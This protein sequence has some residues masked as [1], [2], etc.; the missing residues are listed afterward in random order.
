MQSKKFKIKALQTFK[1]AECPAVR[2][3]AQKMHRNMVTGLFTR[4]S[5]KG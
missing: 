2:E 1:N 4:P 5:K 3:L